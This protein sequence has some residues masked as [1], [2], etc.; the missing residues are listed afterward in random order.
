MDPTF[1]T[2]IA[3]GALFGA[4]YVGRILASR[5]LF[6]EIASNMLEKLEHMKKIFILLR[7]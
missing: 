2:I 3:V 1:H 4:Y 5:R 7:T 6:N